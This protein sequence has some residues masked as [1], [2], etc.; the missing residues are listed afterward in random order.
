M[1]F[2][3]TTKLRALLFMAGTV[4]VAMTALYLCT[5][6]KKS[7]PPHPKWRQE[8]VYST[9]LAS[10][11]S[12]GWKASPKKHPRVFVRFEQG[13]TR[14][15]D[16][17]RGEILAKVQN[18]SRNPS[19]TILIT[20]LPDEG[21]ISYEQVVLSERRAQTVRD[22]LVQ[23]GFNPDR[24]VVKSFG[25]VLPEAISERGGATLEIW[26]PQE[27]LSYY[28]NV[29]SQEPGERFWP[30]S[31]LRP[32]NVKYTVN[33]DL[34][35]LEYKLPG[36]QTFIV[37]KAFRELVEEEKDKGKE[38]LEL[39][40]VLVT[41]RRFFKTPSQILENLE[42][43]LS[44]VREFDQDSKVFPPSQLGEILSNEGIPPF[45]FDRLSFEVETKGT[46]GWGWIGLSFWHEGRPFDE[47]SISFC[48]QHEG[49]MCAEETRGDGLVLA[50]SELFEVNSDILTLRP[51]A[52]L[53]L[54]EFSEYLI[55]GVFARNDSKNASQLKDYKVWTVSHDANAFHK[56]MEEIQRNF[57][58]AKEDPVSVGHSLLNLIFPPRDEE[59][60]L[61]LDALKSFYLENKASEAFSTDRPTLF[62]RLIRR[63]AGETS[64]FPIGLINVD[65]TA[66]GF[67]GFHTK[68][69]MPLPEQDY[70]QYSCPR[71]WQAL[72]PVQT[73]DP[74]LRDA[75]HRFSEHF[76]I[77]PFRP[78]ET[79]YSFG[80]GSVPV[81]SRFDLFNRWID[82]RDLRDAV[83]LLVVSHH[84]RNS[85]YFD[86]ETSILHSQNVSASF[87][88]P[89]VAILAGCSTGQPGAGSVAYELN[90]AGVQ[91]IIA[92]NTGISGALAGDFVELLTRRVQESEE[93]IPI[94]PLLSQVQRDLYELKAA[95]GSAYGPSVL[96]FSFAGNPAVEICR[97]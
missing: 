48:I 55:A 32:E 41:D 23:E 62:V 73:S 47:L 36:V 40:V 18:L 28:W 21:L 31:V 78:T 26:P 45:V 68:L 14:R 44:K 92:T 35:A 94:G 69:Q 24:L 4:T 84:D 6:A 87:T 49:Q 30:I 75:R 95:T 96:S 5:C 58:I 39:D 74:A 2:A 77:N 27:M 88:G 22:V 57:A 42:I 89:S 1:V 70:S 34:S 52:A 29:W 93:P 76:I 16:L 9:S 43:N 64:F 33:V 13:D 3:K 54:I 59:A 20:G 37:E 53:H 80:S 25:E 67:L 81:F 56:N 8:S 10:A 79:L 86:R 65:N 71:S 12:T 50:G 15:F 90:Q 61:A 51:D 17:S 38:T 91:A 63:K 7:A 11:S 72:L 60:D 19:T 46:V 83:T 85:L 82:T 66:D 97:P